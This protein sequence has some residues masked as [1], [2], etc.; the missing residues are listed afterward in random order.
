MSVFDD[1]TIPGRVARREGYGPKEFAPPGRYRALGHFMLQIDL[2][3]ESSSRP[4]GGLW[5]PAFAEMT[6]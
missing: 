3:P 2:G 5:I 6:A 4:K 1:G